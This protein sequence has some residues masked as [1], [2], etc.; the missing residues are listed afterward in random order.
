MRGQARRAGPARIYQGLFS[1]RL[2]VTPGWHNVRVRVVSGD[3]EG[4]DDTAQIQAEFGP[5]SQHTLELS[6]GKAG[7]LGNVA[8]RLSLRWR[9]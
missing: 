3:D 7:F 6:F 5:D 9:K 8:R 1:A 4:F 2:E